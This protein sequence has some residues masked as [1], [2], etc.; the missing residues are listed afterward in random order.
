[1]PLDP[2]SG[3]RF[4]VQYFARKLSSSSKL[5]ILAQR[6]FLTNQHSRWKHVRMTA[7]Y[8]Q[9]LTEFKSVSG[10]NDHLLINLE[11][12][13]PYGCRSLL[14]SQRRWKTRKRAVRTKYHPCNSRSPLNERTSRDCYRTGSEK[15][16]SARCSRDIYATTTRREVRGINSQS[17]ASSR[18][19]G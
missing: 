7:P 9:Q 16:D 15:P 14:S 5:C 12:E 10:I 11:C 17:L 2:T 13:H 6:T 18:G 4:R 3:Q 8:E 19:D 1:M